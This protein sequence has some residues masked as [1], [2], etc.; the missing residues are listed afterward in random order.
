MPPNVIEESNIP[1]ALRDR[2]PLLKPAWHS[3]YMRLLENPFAPRWNAQCGDRIQKDDLEFIDRFARELNT[4]RA[5]RQGV[6]QSIMNF[7]HVMR[8]RSAFFQE[9]LEDLSLEKEFANIPR[10]ERADLQN[11]LQNVIPFDEPLDRLVVNPT[12]G[13]TGQPIQAPNHPKAVGCYIP[14]ILFAL[15]RHGVRPVL[16][17][18]TVAAVQICAQKKTITYATV[19]S[20]A[21]GA[22]FAKINLNPTEWRNDDHPQQFLTQTAAQFLTGDP[23]SFLEAKRSGLVVNALA[24]V[25]TALAL[26]V[27]S[28]R[29][30]EGWAACPVVDFY[31]MNESGPIAYSCPVDPGS[32]H[33]LPPDLYVEVAHPDVTLCR[34]GE[35]GEILLTGGRN[36]FLPLLRYRTGDFAKMNFGACVCGD[37]AP[38]LQGLSTR[39][40]VIFEDARGGS[41]N[42]VD[43]A[44]ILRGY[45]ILQHR[46][47]QN[48]D[49]SLEVNLRV[50][51]I[52]TDFAENSMKEEIVTLFGID[53]IRISTD[54]DP[55][56]GK[57]VPYEKE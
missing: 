6:P 44:R 26:D 56:A 15:E 43:I 21:D 9:K 51:N 11:K 46:I 55:T 1:P 29:S 2:I 38:R 31:S 22:G 37:V 25:S 12:S 41:I 32:F 8:R 13:T 36:P 48:R 39:Q 28:R 45:P 19:H 23:F 4:N 17:S 24:L 33:V 53:S 54:L 10:M 7:L 5:A 14:L 35:R 49:K 34:P 16:D 57:I 27:E 20:Q 30:L 40:T 52:W 47:K 18:T 3:N 42:P 50:D